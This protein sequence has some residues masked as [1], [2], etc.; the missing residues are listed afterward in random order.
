[1]SVSPVEGWWWPPGLVTPERTEARAHVRF[2]IL[3]DSQWEVL[4]RHLD[5]A[6]A[7]LTARSAGAVADVLGR[8]GERFGA[9][10]RDPAAESVA[11]ETGFSLPMARTVV[12]GMASGWSRTA[13]HGLLDAEFTDP[14]VLDGFVDDGDRR[15]RVL[16]RGPTFH[17]GAG[18]VPGVAVT[19]LIRALLV[20]CPSLTK[21]GLGDVALTVSFLEAL[22]EEDPELAS[23]AMASYWP[24]GSPDHASV[25]ARMLEW[26]GQV[27]VYGGDEVVQRVRAS[28]PPSTTVLSHPHKIGIVVAHGGTDAGPVAAAAAVFDQQ[29]CVSPQVVLFLGPTDG[30][31]A[32]SER[33]AAALGSA[34][35]DLPPGSRRTGELSAVH[36]LRG[37]LDL[38]GAAGA[39]V[40]TW[41]RDGEVWTVVRSDLDAVRTVGG[42]TVWV[43]PC[44]SG[45]DVAAALAAL[46]PV[47]QSVGVDVDGV[48]AVPGGGPRGGR[49]RFPDRAHPRA[50]LPH[51]RLAP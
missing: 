21:P 15:V 30:A 5:E 3:S 33:L 9:E 24:G 6:G 39:A 37:T 12:E 16:G 23:C 34:E 17:I 47:L 32:W 36:Q 19:S 38:R 45:E 40:R 26:A 2:P 43:V 25:E 42:R 1:M 27:V 46:G 49:G 14:R 28:V 7:R 18:S 4:L 13:L 11:V 10:L 44:P 41:Y 29:G 51:G 22:H 20:K 48:R 50:S 31:D 35:T 8:V